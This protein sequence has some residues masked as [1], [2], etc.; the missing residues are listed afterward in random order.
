MVR[1]GSKRLLSKTLTTA[2]SAATSTAV[3]ALENATGA[4]IQ[5][6]FDYGSGGTSL[7]VWVQTSLDGGST[8]VDVA[9]F[10]FTTSDARK[11]VNLSARTPVTTLYTATDG[12]LADD[13]CKDG[14][15]GSQWRVKYTSVGTYAGSTTVLVDV[16][17]KQ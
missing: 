11:V 6:N 14:V 10:A 3:D 13:T 7:K 1:A 12:T 4:T 2:N 5:V 8:W 17:F 15:F 9:C 16:V